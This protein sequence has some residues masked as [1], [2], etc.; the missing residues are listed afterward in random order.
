MNNRRGLLVAFGAAS[1]DLVIDRR[2]ALGQPA[3]KPARIGLVLNNANVADMTKAEP[4]DRSARA[5]V[6]GLRDL[7]LIEGRDIAI[8]RRSA[9]GRPERGPALLRDLTDLKVDVIVTT[10]GPLLRAGKKAVEPVPVVVV[11]MG[12]PVAAGLITSLARPGGNI[13]GFTLDAGPAIDG[14]RLDVLR[15]IAPDI[16][17]VA[18]LVPAIEPGTPTLSSETEA[19]ARSLRFTLLPVKVDNPEDFDKVFAGIVR[20]SVQAIVV[21]QS[22]PNFGSMR[23]IIDF[24]ARQRLPAIYELRD[25]VEAGGLISYGT[26]LADLFRRAATYVDK[27]LKGARPADLPVEQP[28]KFEL[29]INL[30]TAR[31][32]ELTIPKSL[33]VR[34][35]EVIH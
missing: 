17:R 29:V 16:S 11:G 31:A 20:D 6:Q 32:L 4:V 24:A 2:Y 8:E 19:A 9:Q 34:A 26:D 14:K 22:G 27:I 23:R 5:F 25:Y 18:V 3:R 1:L 15:Q 7:G 13:T 12:D 10:P 28:T 21:P 30:K 33:L 35:D